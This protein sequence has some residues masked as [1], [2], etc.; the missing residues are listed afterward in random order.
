M[1]YLKKYEGFSF[2]KSLKTRI[3]EILQKSFQD[4]AYNKSE[5]S[6]SFNIKNNYIFIQIVDQGYDGFSQ[7]RSIDISVN[8]RKVISLISDIPKNFIELIHRGIEKYHNNNNYRSKV[9]KATKELE[10]EVDKD[11]LNMIF[12]DLRDSGYVDDINITYKSDLGSNIKISFNSK[13]N[14]KDFKSKS[15]FYSILD[16]IIIQ[17][18]SSYEEFEIEVS[19]DQQSYVIDMIKLFHSK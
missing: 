12:S 13:I 10:N 9:E 18:K 16:T 14:I 7:N 11:D 5:L 8:N 15:E 2:F 6:W 17:I 3:N 4:V 1:N 19:N